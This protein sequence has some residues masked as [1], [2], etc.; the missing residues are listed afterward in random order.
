ML[1]ASNALNFESYDRRMKPLAGYVEVPDD[2]LQERGLSMRRGIVGL[3]PPD[4]IR[5]DK[6]QSKY[7]PISHF[8]HLCGWKLGSREA[9]QEYFDLMVKSRP[10]TALRKP[11]YTV[12]SAEFCCWNSFRGQDVRVTVEDGGV[13]KVTVVDCDGEQEMGDEATLWKELGICS[14]LRF[15]ALPTPLFRSLY[16]LEIES[17]PAL[18]MIR[19]PE[20]LSEAE[21]QY[22]V[23]NHEKSEDCEVAV[24]AF[25]I[26]L[27]DWDV[28]HRL[29]KNVV[30]RKMPRVMHWLYVLLPSDLPVSKKMLK[31][32][33]LAYTQYPDDD[34]LA[35]TLVNFCVQADS[36]SDCDA[37]LPLLKGNMWSSPVACC[38]M[39]KVMLMA[40]RQEDSL[41]CINAA[42]YAKTFHKTQ[43]QTV[44]TVV[45]RVESKKAPRARP[46]VIE[47]EVFESQKYDLE[48]LLYET[49]HDVIKVMTP[50]KVRTVLKNRF[51]VS[52]ENSIAMGNDGVGH[53]DVELPVI[54]DPELDML[55]DPGVVGDNQL[56]DVIKQLPLCR[57]MSQLL[58]TLTEDLALRDVAMKGRRWDTSAEVR[59][60][61]FVA[62]KLRDWQMVYSLGP[63]IKSSK[64][65]KAIRQLIM[66][67]LASAPRWNSVSRKISK[68]ELTPKGKSINEYNA[69]IIMYCLADG[70]HTLLK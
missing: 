45:P 38:A 35:L 52:K 43:H 2:L 58:T 47:R 57:Q 36:E 51:Q 21:I 19:K 6:V 42:F 68:T 34:V 39:A 53:E 63:F 3:G 5:L 70:M 59:K 62:L 64:K 61:L 56:P 7:S 50:S 40:G 37:V 30:L 22:F 17:Y 13:T 55:F 8:H 33:R 29:L 31:Q 67:R 54:Q 65:L 23:E 32:A 1:D 15:W 46:S 25:L 49:L 4:L 11:R 20:A 27:G 48:C 41:Y 10:R 69:M 66:F 26:S 60:A 18:K 14:V 44:N 28:I 24:A 16:S 9:V 12:K